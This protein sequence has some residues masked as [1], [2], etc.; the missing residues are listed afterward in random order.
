MRNR[1]THV[2]PTRLPLHLA[3][4]KLRPAYLLVT[5]CAVCVAGLGAGGVAGIVVGSLLVIA[6]LIAVL[7]L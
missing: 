4:L 6:A 7:V 5:M 2:A 1:L 3:Q